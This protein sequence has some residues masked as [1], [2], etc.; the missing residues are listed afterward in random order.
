MLKLARK[1]RKS[2]N[3]YLIKLFSKKMPSDEGIFFI[4]LKVQF[5]V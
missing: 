4:L 5:V 2:S 1:R 3:Q